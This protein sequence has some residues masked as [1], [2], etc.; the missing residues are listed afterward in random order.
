MKV[1][2]K[3]FEVFESKIFKQFKV[4]EK[5]EEL[6]ATLN[7]AK[8]DDLND[9]EVMVIVPAFDKNMRSI[10]LYNTVLFCTYRNDAH[11]LAQIIIDNTRACK[12]HVVTDFIQANTSIANIEGRL[13]CVVLLHEFTMVEKSNI[14]EKLTGNNVNLEYFELC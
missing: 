4:E 12:V 7:K 10:C 2:M 9:Q 11:D 3:N 8:L 1:R 6:Q 13:S 5:I 14:L